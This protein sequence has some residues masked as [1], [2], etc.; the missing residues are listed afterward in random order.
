MPPR[1]PKYD[2]AI[3]FLAQ[4]E[5]LA[6]SVLGSLQPPHSVFVYSKAQ[7]H[8]AGRDGIEAFRTVF[9]EQAQLAVILYRQGWGETPWTR[10]ERTAIEEFAHEEGW[11]RLMFVR[12]DES[13]V[14]KWVPRPHLYLDYNRFTLTDLTGAVKS[15][16]AELDVPIKVVT[17]AE[18]AEAMARQRAFHEETKE[19]LTRSA[20]D[21]LTAQESLFEGL[22]EEAVAVS[23]RTGWRVAAGIGAGIGGFVVSAEGQGLQI[24]PQNLYANSARDACLWIREYAANLIV[25]EPG[26]RYFIPAAME[27]TNTR[28]LD[29][30]RMPAP[31][32]W[33]WE[34]EG[35]V[36]PP[37]EAARA[38]M[39][40]LLDRIE[41]RA[42]RDRD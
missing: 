33:C 14:P 12:L 42:G 25:A 22:K 4:D 18:R 36:Y 30:R 41:S 16:L 5:A 24:V 9:R 7:E 39:G 29:I 6:L 8:L 31:L 19:L 3:S 26:M 13:P 2:V 10:V 23:S 38:V 27:F 40:V 1:G 20:E 32:G 34:L 15:R 37:K 21:F 11:E 17:P 28:R 35:R